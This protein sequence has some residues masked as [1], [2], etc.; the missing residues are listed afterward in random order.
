MIV[1][2]PNRDRLA[3]REAEKTVRSPKAPGA[4][5]DERGKRPSPPM[6]SD[7]CPTKFQT[8]T[9]SLLTPGPAATG[10]M[11]IAKKRATAGLPS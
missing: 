1:G 2:D 9:Q 8:T 3:R 4:N 7:T 10:S 5:R 11:V 6:C